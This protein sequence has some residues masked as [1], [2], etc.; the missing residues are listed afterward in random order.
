MREDAEQSQLGLLSSSLPRSSSSSLVSSSS[1][2]TA[3][4]PTRSRESYEMETITN[5]Q[6]KHDA[7]ARPSYD[8]RR[9]QTGVRVWKPPPSRL[10][11]LLKILEQRIFNFVQIY[12]FELGYMS[13]WEAVS[14]VC[15]SARRE[16]WTVNIRLT[17]M[18]EH[19]PRLLERRSSITSLGVF[20]CRPYSPM[21]GRIDC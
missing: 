2:Y 9:T 19:R 8:A 21:P 14:T 5:S 7:T 18:Q 17:I 15:Q 16:R 10:R 4:V 6:H 1:Q 11:P 13:S 12:F 3:R 20:H